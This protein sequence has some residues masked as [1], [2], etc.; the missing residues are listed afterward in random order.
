MPL[1]RG[2]WMELVLFGHRLGEPLF[3]STSTCRGPCHPAID[4]SAGGKAPSDLRSMEEKLRQRSLPV[5]LLPH[6]N[7]YLL[8]GALS[9]S[10]CAMCARSHSSLQWIRDSLSY[11]KSKSKKSWICKNI[12]DRDL[13]VSNSSDIGLRYS[14]VRATK[15]NKKYFA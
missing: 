3:A 14:A 2:R 5:S 15:Q 9:G 8:C 12:E 11:K 13:G 6:K 1:W 4:C 7:A 10:I